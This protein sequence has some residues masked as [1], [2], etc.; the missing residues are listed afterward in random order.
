MDYR[1]QNGIVTPANPAEPDGDVDAIRY[2]ERDGSF[3]FQLG[4]GIGQQVRITGLCTDRTVPWDVD[5]CRA[6]A[7]VWEIADLAWAKLCD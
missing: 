1:V 6:A 7:L 4:S 5:W 2:D 3:E